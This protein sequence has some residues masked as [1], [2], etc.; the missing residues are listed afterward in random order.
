MLLAWSNAFFIWAYLSE[1]SFLIRFLLSF[2]TEFRILHRESQIPF[3]YEFMNI[4]KQLK[5]ESVYAT[6]KIDQ[7]T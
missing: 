2:S 4:K 7:S 5:K 6:R 3:L 1:R